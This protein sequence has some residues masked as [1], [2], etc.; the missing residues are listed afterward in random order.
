LSL[1]S[2]LILLTRSGFQQS[3]FFMG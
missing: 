2:A 3:L 1:P